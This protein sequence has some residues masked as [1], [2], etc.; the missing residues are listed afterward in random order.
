MLEKI[1]ELG[2]KLPLNSMD[3]LI[4]D[5]GGPENVAEMTGRKSRVVMKKDGKVEFESRSE[6][7]ES[8]DFNVREKNSFMSGEKLVAIISEASSTGISLQ[9]DRLVKNQ[10]RRL[11]ITIELPWGPDK[12][13]QQFGR[14]HRSNQRFVSSLAKRLQ[15]LDAL[16]HGDRRAYEQRDLDQFNV[17]T[18][19]GQAAVKAILEAV[20]GRNINPIVSP[21]ADYE[22]KFFRD[23]K[24]GLENVGI[25]DSNDINVTV[26]LNRLLGM[27][28]DLQKT[29]FQYFTE[30][31][32]MAILI[33]ASSIWNLPPK[34]YKEKKPWNKGISWR[35]EEE[36]FAILDGANEGFYVS[37]REPI[38]VQLVAKSDTT[39]FYTITRPNKGLILTQKTL[40]DVGKLFRMISI[41]EAKP[42][43]KAE[44]KTS[45]TMC[46][47]ERWG[48]KCDQ[49][50]G[51]CYIGLRYDPC[52]ILS[53]PVLS[54]WAKV[55]AVITACGKMDIVRLR[56]GDT[57][58]IGIYVPSSCIPR[59]IELLT[60]ESENVSEKMF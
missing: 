27:P 18:E 17:E 11:H 33:L 52:N 46:Y 6:S 15:N 29:L 31:K 54:V 57:G 42:L 32:K 12:A 49:S 41:E 9:A 51:K 30:P 40:A 53:G 2:E 25:T 26:F 47:H 23:A 58:N 36:K 48:G 3:Q 10:R 35:R 28:V 21:P 34:K 1:E 37:T 56:S 43:W 50:T 8:L 44:F 59:I 16:I 60:K 4:H 13:I 5:F 45:K 22:G 24:V 20:M 7:G 14:T 19:Y 55:E 39:G 38:T